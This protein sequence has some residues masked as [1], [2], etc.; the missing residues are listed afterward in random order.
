QWNKTI[1]RHKLTLINNGKTP[2]QAVCANMRKLIHICFDVIKNQ[3]AFKL[4]ES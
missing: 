3:E 1:K 4:Q 2:M